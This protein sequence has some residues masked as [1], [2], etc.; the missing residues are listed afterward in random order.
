[1]NLKTEV[2]RERTQRNGPQP[3][4]PAPQAKAQAT[5]A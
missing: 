2:G 4:T 1:M 3:S 5:A